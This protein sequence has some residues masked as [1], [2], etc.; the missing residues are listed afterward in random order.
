MTSAGALQKLDFSF[1]DQA[2]FR[3][4]YALGEKKNRIRFYVEGI[5]CSKCVRK[6]EDLPFS[7]NG[8]KRLRVEMG[9]NLAHAEIDT[10]VLSFAAL[11][12]KISE[13]GFRPIPVSAEMTDES[14]MWRE[15]RAELIR[16]GV[17]AACAGNIMT[18]SF[19]NYLGA[20]EGFSQVF[21][22]LSF[23]LYL[24]VLTFVAKPFY[25]GAWNS[26]KQ[27]QAWE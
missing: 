11:A 10:D 22:W 27:K 24:P 25:L 6:L 17:A 19:A 15:D 3:S 26:L 4:K 13:M 18:F 23:L 14:L 9:K 1:L 8:L 21:S 7:V 5:Q 2:D 16:L 20:A 12:A